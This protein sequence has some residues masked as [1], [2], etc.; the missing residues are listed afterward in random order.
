M[1]RCRL[2]PFSLFLAGITFGA[3]QWIKNDDLVI[4]VEEMV[5]KVQPTRTE[6]RFDEIGWAPT[7]LAAEALAEKLG[8]PMFLFVY[9]GKIDT[10]RC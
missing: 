5:R 3:D 4:S 6:K 7:I 2:L 10:G 8:R 9:N 1:R